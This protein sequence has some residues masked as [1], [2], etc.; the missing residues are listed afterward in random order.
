MSESICGTHII[1][2]RPKSLNSLN[3]LAAVQ[4]MIYQQQGFF[5]DHGNINTMN[6]H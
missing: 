3:M 5:I 6:R 1:A 4:A 2:L